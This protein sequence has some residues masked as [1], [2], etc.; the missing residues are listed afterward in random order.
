MQ[1]YS[2]GLER[3]RITRNTVIGFQFLPQADA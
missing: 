3:P 1:L 2:R